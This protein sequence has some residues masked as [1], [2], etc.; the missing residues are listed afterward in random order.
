M[1]LTHRW[2][3]RRRWLWEARLSDCDR[4]FRS[5]RSFVVHFSA[6]KEPCSR[7]LISGSHLSLTHENAHEDSERDDDGDQY[8]IE[9]GDALWWRYI[10]PLIFI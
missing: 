2:L 7:E 1:P 6:S 10:L 5:L 4:L 3:R 9:L 8:L